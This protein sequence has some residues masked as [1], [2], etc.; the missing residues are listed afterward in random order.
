MHY[1]VGRPFT[2]SRYQTIGLLEAGVRS[3]TCFVLP[4]NIIR[5]SLTGYSNAMYPPSVL[6]NILT[7]GAHSHVAVL[8]GRRYDSGHI[9]V[10]QREGFKD[11]VIVAS[12]LGWAEGRAVSI[13]QRAV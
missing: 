13:A 11:I 10:G 1:S 3:G 7:A 8:S 12:T 5:L 9:T 4:V 2:R 6:Q